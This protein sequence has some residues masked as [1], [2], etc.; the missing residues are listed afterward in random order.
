[1]FAI[2]EGAERERQLAKVGGWEIGEGPE[3]WGMLISAESWGHDIIFSWGMPDWVSWRGLVGESWGALDGESLGLE[4]EVST[5]ASNEVSCGVQAGGSLDE[6]LVS[7]RT[8]DGLSLL[9]SSW[10]GGSG[11]PITRH[12]A[13]TWVTSLSCWTLSLRFSSCSLTMASARGVTWAA[14]SPRRA[15]TRFPKACRSVWI[16]P[17]AHRSVNSKS[18]WQNCSPS[19]S[20]SSWASRSPITSSRPDSAQA[21]S[22]LLNASGACEAGRKSR[23][24]PGMVRPATLSF[25]VV[26]VWIQFNPLS[27][28]CSWVVRPERV[29]G[30]RLRGV[31]RGCLPVCLSQTFQNNAWSLY[32][33]QISSLYQQTPWQPMSMQEILF[34]R[35]QWLHP[36]I[37]RC[38]GH[39]YLSPVLLLFHWDS[40]SWDTGWGQRG[41]GWWQQFKTLSPPSFNFPFI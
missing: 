21:L 33:Q 41:N 28:N 2:R 16:S 24:T 10:S 15:F 30:L 31:G 23:F 36:L 3:F 11:C 39:V 19:F 13:S 22:G 35:Q 8:E 34:P 20:A 9:H 12:R 27:Q 38:C 29:C 17:T 4:D 1:M 14:A 7:Q 32:P 40:Q 26:K 25:T 37:S 6:V 18:L 5:S